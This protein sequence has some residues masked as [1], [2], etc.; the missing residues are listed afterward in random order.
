VWWKLERSVSN[1][2][3]QIAKCYSEH[4]VR[5]RALI[6]ILI[7][8]CVEEVTPGSAIAADFR[9]TFHVAGLPDTKRGQRVDLS[10]G[11]DELIFEGG[12]GTRSTYR[13]PYRRVKQALLLRSERHYEK[14]TVTAA[15]ATGAFGVPVGALLILKKHKMDAV[16]IDYENERGGRMGVV[17]QLDRNQKQ[18]LTV[19]LKEHGVTVI[20]PPPDQSPPA[21][22]K[23]PHSKSKV[24]E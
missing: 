8:A 24:Q 17:L 20:D 22:V 10:F 5:T 18:D 12:S 4:S 6:C 3:F 15:A 13:L 19:R 9:R 23:K 2:G 21:S 1:A 14:T 16:V 11:A 7:V